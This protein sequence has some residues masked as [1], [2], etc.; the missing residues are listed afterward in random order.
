M[1]TITAVYVSWTES[2][3]GWG[4]RPDGCSIHL[5]MDEWA[6]YFREWNASQ[7]KEVPAEYTAPGTPKPIDISDEQLIDT[8]KKK[9]SLRFWNGHAT[10]VKLR[11]SCKM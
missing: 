2:E 8:L 11:Q 7:P 10:E 5:S 4:M 9:K 6:R 3:R 1:P